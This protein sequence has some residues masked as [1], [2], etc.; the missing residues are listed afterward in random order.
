MEIMRQGLSSSGTNIPAV[1]HEEVASPGVLHRG[2]DKKT[3]LLCQAHREDGMHPA[4]A[5]RQ[6]W[7]VS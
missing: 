1:R 7:D 6:D 5:P 4:S 3:F 2:A